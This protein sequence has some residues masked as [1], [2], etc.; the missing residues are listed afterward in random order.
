MHFIRLLIDLKFH[1]FF[2]KLISRVNEQPRVF[3]S[4]KFISI[5]TI[6]KYLDFS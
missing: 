1:N 3:L 5:E 6:L 4:R 2:V